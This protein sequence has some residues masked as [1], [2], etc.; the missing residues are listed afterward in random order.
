MTLID[1]DTD[2]DNDSDNDSDNDNDNDNECCAGP[3]DM[4]LFSP[5]FGAICTTWELT[6]C[7]RTLFGDGSEARKYETWSNVGLTTLLALPIHMS[8]S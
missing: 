7:L 6:L 2:N 5:F 8:L 3:L 4:V 1:T